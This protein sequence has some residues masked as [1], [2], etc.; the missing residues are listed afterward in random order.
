V[1]L[2]AQR[3]ERT[4]QHAIAERLQYKSTEQLRALPEIGASSVQSTEPSLLTVLC[5]DETINLCLAGL[6]AETLR[7]LKSVG[8]IWQDRVQAFIVQ[9]AHDHASQLDVQISQGDRLAHLKALALVCYVAPDAG[10][11][12]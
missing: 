2:N 8:S 4:L 3:A 7:S 5:D 11:S 1:F 9:Y 6:S 10:M 12:H